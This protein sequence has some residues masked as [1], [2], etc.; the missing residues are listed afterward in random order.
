M[1]G[2]TS[3]NDIYSDWSERY[4]EYLET[5]STVEPQS[6]HERNE[7]WHDAFCIG[8]VQAE[9]YDWAAAYL[10]GFDRIHGSVEP[11]YRLSMEEFNEELQKLMINVV[12]IRSGK[13][14][15]CPIPA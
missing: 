3:R 13:K 10:D 1:S 8:E 9:S 11:D 5:D 2:T 4:L 7:E 6:L 15:Y 12:N 14:H